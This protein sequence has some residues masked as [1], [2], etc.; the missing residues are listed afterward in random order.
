[1]LPSL[2]LLICTQL[3]DKGRMEKLSYRIPSLTKYF[4]QGTLKF[5]K[6]YFI[7][8]TFKDSG[9]AGIYIQNAVFLSLI[10]TLSNMQLQ[11]VWGEIKFKIIIFV[12]LTTIW[13]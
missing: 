5:E 6:L 11:Y 10:P 4:C 1:M 12:Y 9:K 2:F 3:N 8:F 7:C 13:N